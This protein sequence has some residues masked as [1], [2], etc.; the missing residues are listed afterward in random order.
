MS[1]SFAQIAALG[2]LCALGLLVGYVLLTR[3]R[4][5]NG[6]IGPERAF[7][8]SFNA[9]FNENASSLEEAKEILPA[10]AGRL[11]QTTN[12]NAAQTGKNAGSPVQGPDGEGNSLPASRR[13]ATALEAGL[14]FAGKSRS[15]VAVDERLKISAKLPHVIELIRTIEKEDARG[16]D[17]GADSVIDLCFAEGAFDPLLSLGGFLDG[18]F[19]NE[20]DFTALRAANDMMQA[21][22]LLLGLR[23]EYEIDVP[24][25]LAL[26][27]RNDPR[28]SG[29]D[30]RQISGIDAVSTIV[31][32]ISVS[33]NPE[34]AMVVDCPVAQVKQNGRIL[35]KGVVVIYNR[36]AWV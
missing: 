3:V 1:I 9:L 8:N 30:V 10:L 11:S 23:R 15:F 35:R 12:A 20:Q 24:S 29:N 17:K 14:R 27:S 4:R 31:D 28:V 33:I 25:P 32:R 26:I 16:N 18:Y 21:H 22:V 13:L 34:Q 6:D 5:S 2:S 36:S 7:L 19:R